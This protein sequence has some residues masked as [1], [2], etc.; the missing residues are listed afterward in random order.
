MCLFGYSAFIHLSVSLCHLD[1]FERILSQ[2]LQSL[3]F[4]FAA[5]HR[6]NR[7]PGILNFSSDQ[8]IVAL[9]VSQIGRV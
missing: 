8:I 7:V 5:T 2:L 4:A 6:V 1:Q 3:A 9:P